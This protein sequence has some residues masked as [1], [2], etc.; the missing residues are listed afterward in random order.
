MKIVFFG[1]SQFAVSALKRLKTGSHSVIAAVTQ[2]AKK[3][4][5]HLKISVSP[6]EK[7]A[8]KLHIPILQPH[9]MNEKDFINK[10]KGFDTDFFVVVA[11]NQS[12]NRISNCIQIQVELRSTENRSTIPFGNYYLF[13][14]GI[15]I[16]LLVITK[17]Y[18]M[19]IKN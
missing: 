7:E 13:Y 12:G 6:I 4:G 19:H 11:Y 8:Q 10:L 17:K 1:T 5:R 14:I 18:L 15:T 9:S 3:A 16:I 2:P